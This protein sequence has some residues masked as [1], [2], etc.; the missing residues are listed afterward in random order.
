MQISNTE[1]KGHL[2]ELVRCAEAEPE[3]VRLFVAEQDRPI[4]GQIESYRV[5]Q[6]I[7]E[8]KL[9]RLPVLHVCRCKA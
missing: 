5:G 8:R 7:R 2:T 4:D 6:L 1:A 9:P 3:A